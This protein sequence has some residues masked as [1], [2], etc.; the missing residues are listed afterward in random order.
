V[1]RPKEVHSDD[2]PT[3]PASFDFIVDALSLKAGVLETKSLPLYPV[4]F[5]NSEPDS[6]NFALCVVLGVLDFL[7]EVLVLG[8]TDPS[9][10]SVCFDSE[11]DLT[12]SGCCP[13]N[14][15]NLKVFL[16]VLALKTGVFDGLTS[17]PVCSPS[18]E[19][20]HLPVRAE[21]D[22]DSGERFSDSLPDL[23]EEYSP[24]V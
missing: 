16:E 12:Q 18:G 15:L 13:P 24:I 1:L 19:D 2:E 6:S 17:L 4:L 5:G 14:T 7:P 21:L 9:L 10:P 11:D 22:P 8:A 3:P 20:E 23:L